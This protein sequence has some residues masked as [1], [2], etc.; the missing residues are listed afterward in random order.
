M[1]PIR[2]PFN[3]AA[4]LALMAFTLFQVQPLLANGDGWT[5][6]DSI[7]YVLL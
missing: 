2:L 7:C 1:N 5:D 3:T 6:C 4:I